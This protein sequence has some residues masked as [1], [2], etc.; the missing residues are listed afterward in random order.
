M[1][2]ETPRQPGDIAHLV[3]EEYRRF[4]HI[5]ALMERVRAMQKPPQEPPRPS[6]PSRTYPTI[7][8]DNPWDIR[9]ACAR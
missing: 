9:H 8:M 3:D 2:T 6:K 5:A 4:A 1:G 7:F